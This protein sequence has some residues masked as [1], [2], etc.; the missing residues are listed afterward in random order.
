M[1]YMAWTLMDNFEWADGYDTRFGLVYVDFEQ[2]K[3]LIKDSGY[4]FQSF[5]ER[6][7]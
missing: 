1:G 4:W 5:L 2:Q 3:R 7:S 6:N